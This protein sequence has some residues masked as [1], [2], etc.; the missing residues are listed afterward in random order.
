VAVTTRRG[1]HLWFRL[2]RFAGVPSTAGR[3]ARGVDTRGSGGYAIAWDP[4]ALIAGR[5]R[6]AEWSVWLD[7]ALKPPAPPPPP[8]LPPP[9]PLARGSDAESRYAAAALRRGVER[10]AMARE[11][12]RNDALNR[13]AWALARLIGRGLDA[14][15]IRTALAI[16]AR[17]A[18]LGP[19]E[20]D[21]TI[22]S[23]LRARG[24]LQ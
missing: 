16:A 17:V 12:T 6:M 11:G 1:L 9:S 4:P 22:E 2:R 14:A 13:E 21:A 5:A 19:R 24:A 18:G 3:I 15:S 7:D 23:A 8:P 20:A 10:V